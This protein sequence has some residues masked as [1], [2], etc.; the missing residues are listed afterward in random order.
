M[1]IAAPPE[2]RQLRERKSKRE[3]ELLKCA[4]EAILLA[5]RQT[6]KQMHIG[7]RESDARNLIARALA[8]AGLKEG[9]CLTLFG[10]NVALPH[11]SG[12][13]RRLRPQDFALFDSLHGYWSDVTRT[14]ALPASTIPDIHLQIWNFVHSAQNIAFGTAHAGVVAKR[15]DEATR[16]FLGLTGY[17]C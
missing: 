14:L 16:L 1:V 17:A 11:G 13:D 6:H 8:D 15:V 7:M 12:T 4:N 2:I 3:L 9:G 5:I 10:E